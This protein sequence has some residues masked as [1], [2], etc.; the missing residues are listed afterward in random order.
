MTFNI[1]EFRELG[2]PG[3]GV[4]GQSGQHKYCSIIVTQVSCP[5]ISPDG[6]DTSAK[7]RC[8]DELALKR[9]DTSCT[10]YRFRSRTFYC[11]DSCRDENL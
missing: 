5:F 6:S 9:R 3:Q 2:V 4:P 1:E 7:Q 10:S 11:A 8:R